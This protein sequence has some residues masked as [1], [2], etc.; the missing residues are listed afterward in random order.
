MSYDNVEIDKK[1]QPELA[2]ALHSI[3]DVLEI[4]EPFTAENTSTLAK[5]WITAS[6]IKMGA[7]MPVLRASLTG[8]TQ[9][10]D[11]YEIAAILGKDKTVAR[12]RKMAD[13]KK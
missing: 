6:G 2:T 10:P 4:A 3:A 11:V 12:L 1:W 5:E 7:I 9:G 8:T 13:R